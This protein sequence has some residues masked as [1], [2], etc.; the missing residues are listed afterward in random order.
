MEGVGAEFADASVG[1]YDEGQGEGVPVFVGVFFVLGGG[2]EGAP[3]AAIVGG[4]VGAVGAYGDPGFGGGGVGYGGAVA[5]GWGLGWLD[6][7]LNKQC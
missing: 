6:G 1:A 5:V 2:G 3:V 7:D 4:D